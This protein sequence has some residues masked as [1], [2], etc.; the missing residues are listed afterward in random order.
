M[1]KSSNRKP[2]AAHPVAKA[3]VVT[4]ADTAPAAVTRAA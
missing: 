1:S 3:P 4:V 2:P